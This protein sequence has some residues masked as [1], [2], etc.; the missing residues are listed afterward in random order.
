MIYM[1][2]VLVVIPVREGHKE[3]LEKAGKDCVFVYSSAESITN[4]ELE[5]ANVIIGNVPAGRLGA[6]RELEWLQLNSAGADGYVKPG[7]LKAGVILTNA[8][9]AYHKAVAEHMFALMLMLQKKLHL[10]RD[11]QNKSLWADEGEVVSVS[12]CRVLVV[13][14]GDIGQHFARLTKAFGG[15]V[16]GVKRRKSPCPDCAD[17]LYTSEKLN[18]VLPS[19][20][21][22]VSFLPGM[23]ANR[24]IYTEESFRLMKKTAVFLNGGRG[25][26]VD[27]AVLYNAL[28]NG[29]IAAAGLDVTEPEPLPADNPLWRLP[30]VMIT[31]HISGWYH[32]PET[33]ER[34]VDIAA[35]NLAAY[36]TGGELK[37]IV[38]FE[39][40]YRK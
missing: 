1:K 8:T 3:K 34:I 25:N 12:D 10:Y 19:A 32:L 30:N 27:T 22:V 15:Y 9:G 16:I 26:A 2:N 13:G 36:T 23:E 35:E 14:L 28:K 7:V 21:V 11:N 17:E 29:E 20:D 37:N 24:H 4:E 18:E 31:P 38:D 33:F 5:R 39:T 40:G 6:C